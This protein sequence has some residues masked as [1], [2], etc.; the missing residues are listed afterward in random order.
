[1]S[2]VGH[3]VIL[4]TLSCHAIWNSSTCTIHTYRYAVNTM[5]SCRTFFAA[6]CKGILETVAVIYKV[7]QSKILLHNFVCECFEMF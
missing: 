5:E 1:M 7:G 3:I 2:A 4:L 6:K